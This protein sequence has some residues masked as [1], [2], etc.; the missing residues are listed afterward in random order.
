MQH[1]PVCK[2][3][4]IQRSR[5]RSRWERWRKEITEKRPFRCQACGWRG[6]G[7]DTGPNLGDIERQGAARSL[8]P[9]PPNLRNLSAWGEPARPRLL[10]LKALDAIELSPIDDRDA[11]RGSFT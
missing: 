4:D 2:S 6:W 3:A 1:C 7:F 9:Q 10:A 5:S 11:D 8:A